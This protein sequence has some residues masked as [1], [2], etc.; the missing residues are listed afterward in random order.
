MEVTPY[1]QGQEAI[2]K[3]DRKDK[4]RLNNPPVGLVTPET[5]KDNPESVTGGDRRSVRIVLQGG[6]TLGGEGLIIAPDDGVSLCS[7]RY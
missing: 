7:C 5:D 6:L 3:Y 1:A 2:E 4:Q